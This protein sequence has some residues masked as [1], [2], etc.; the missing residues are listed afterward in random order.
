MK[1]LT[2]ESGDDTE[3]M[4]DEGPIFNFKYNGGDNLK[5]EK[6]SIASGGRKRGRVGVDRSLWK[7]VGESGSRDIVR[8]SN[9][10]SEKALDSWHKRTKG[11]YADKIAGVYEKYNDD[12]TTP[13]FVV[14]RVVPGVE[15][16][17]E[18]PLLAVNGYTTRLSDY[19]IRKEYYDAPS[20]YDPKTNKF[21]G[22]KHKTI[23]QFATDKFNTDYK[24]DELVD[25]AGY[26]TKDY[27]DAI[28]E[29]KRQHKGR[30]H[31][32]V[33]SPYNLFAKNIITAAYNYVV[34]AYSK[35]YNLAIEDIKS[36][37]NKQFGL[38]W[39]LKLTSKVWNDEIKNPFLNQL[40]NIVSGY[41]SK[42][43]V[44]LSEYLADNPDAK[45]TKG[46]K[47]KLSSKLNERLMNKKEVKNAFKEYCRE[48]LTPDTIS[49]NAIMTE[50]GE[51]FNKMCSRIIG[52]AEVNLGE[53][54]SKSLTDMEMSS[55]I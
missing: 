20:M 18:W 8:N 38:G 22:G 9:W 29:L 47:N 46:L 13:E 3:I 50:L 48:I 1:A 44:L 24:L 30:I 55:G 11:K 31:F 51:Y 15:N 21:L 14:R 16:R 52:E 36:A 28:K 26:P 43:N 34:V 27:M 49:W 17:D 19:P 54:D 33:P 37:I 4:E 40:P 32:T 10:I 45:A 5:K 53:I 39:I 12:D 6:I 2:H 25:A 42:L 7:L 35:K 23:G 41:D